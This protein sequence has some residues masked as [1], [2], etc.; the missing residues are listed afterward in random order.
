MNGGGKKRLKHVE[1]VGQVKDK[2]NKIAANITKLSTQNWHTSFSAPGRFP[3][4]ARLTASSKLFNCNI[5]VI[6]VNSFP[7]SQHKSDKKKSETYLTADKIH[8]CL[9]I[10]SSQ[11]NLASPINGIKSSC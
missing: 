11:Q 10:N 2:S 3:L 1:S 7:A 5:K 6:N 9:F 4:L 8:N